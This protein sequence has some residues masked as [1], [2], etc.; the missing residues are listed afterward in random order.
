MRFAVLVPNEFSRNPQTPDSKK[1][2]HPNCFVEY[3]L[4]AKE[5]Y[6]AI[7]DP[8]SVKGWASLSD[9][10][11]IQ[12]QRLLTVSKSSKLSV[13][14]N[15]NDN[16]SHVQPA[17]KRSRAHT[18]GESHAVTAKLRVTCDPRSFFS[19]C[20]R[21]QAPSKKARHSKSKSPQQAAATVPQQAD[22]NL[23]Q[24][25][26]TTQPVPAT[27][28]HATP[29]QQADA[30]LPQE[31][32]FSLPQQAAPSL[33]QH[34]VPGSP[35]Q[36]AA[37]LLQ[38]ADAKLPPK[39]AATLAELVRKCTPDLVSPSASCAR[40][41]AAEKVLIIL[42]AYPASTTNDITRLA[43]NLPGAT[44]TIGKKMTTFAQ[45]AEP[46]VSWA[47]AT[48]PRRYYLSPKGHNELVQL[49]KFKGHLVPMGRCVCQ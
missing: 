41:T 46:V 15:I 25:A 27:P 19:D 21:L 28:P 5:Q 38:Q 24:Q 39:T 6:A 2:F 30:K 4:R 37:S 36:V 44:K 9:E 18:D 34:A 20:L 14:V 42:E 7:E 49:M 1:C 10:E 47:E 17:G 12:T 3:R 26:A 11:K 35:Q 13:F 8:S 31:A 48:F 45:M 23:P 32:P 40:L 33:P 22:D 16:L 29:L 43:E